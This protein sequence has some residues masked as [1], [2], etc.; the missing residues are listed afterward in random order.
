L[1]SGASVTDGDLHVRYQRFERLQRPTMIQFQI[2]PNAEKTTRVFIDRAY[3]DAVRIESITPQPEKVAANPGGSIYDFAAAGAP[4]VVTIYLE[5]EQF[6]VVKG[7]IGRAG[8]ST[9][10]FTQLVYP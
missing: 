7:Q 1:L 5:M 4:I 9:L 3:L 10:S 2:G 8:G 6:G